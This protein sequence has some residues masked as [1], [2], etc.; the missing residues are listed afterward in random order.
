LEDEKERLQEDSTN[1]VD[2]RRIWT[3]NDKRCCYPEQAKLGVDD[4]RTKL[5]SKSEEYSSTR[6]NAYR[7]YFS[8]L[9]P[10]EGESHGTMPTGVIIMISGILKILLWRNILLPCGI[11]MKSC[12][13]G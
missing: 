13:A 11:D 7:Y 1:N 2:F 3:G 4:Q 6:Q 5:P 9:S 12:T 8:R 10:R